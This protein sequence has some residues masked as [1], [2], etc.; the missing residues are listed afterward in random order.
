VIY[1]NTDSYSK[2]ARESYQSEGPDRAAG[3]GEQ[4]LTPGPDGTHTVDLPLLSRC[5]A[6]PICSCGRPRRSSAGAAGRP[7]WGWPR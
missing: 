5:G 6:P 1:M 3:P 7:A 4:G 2:F